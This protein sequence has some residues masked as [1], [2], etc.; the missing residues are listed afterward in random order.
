M[1]M[2]TSNPVASE[3][4]IQQERQDIDASLRFPVL[5]L[6]TTALGWLLVSILLGFIASI[7]LHSPEFL[8]N[9]SWLTYGRVSPAYLHTFIYGWAI[10][11]GL[12]AALWIIAR[13]NGVVFGR[14]LL[15]VIAGLVWNV[16]VI[17]GTLEILSGNSQGFEFF[18][19][20]RYVVVILLIGYSL[21]AAWS[22][23]I[24]KA[25][26]GIKDS[27]SIWYFIAAIIW[28]PWLLGAAALILTA[29]P[30]HGVVLSLVSAWFAQNLIGLWF[31][32]V[33]LGIIYYLIPKITG[34]P[35]YSRSLASLG[36]WSFALISGWTSATR[37]TGGPL[38]VWLVTVGIGASLL[39]LI[40]VAA[41]SANLFLSLQGN[42]QKI[43]KEPA[44]GFAGF[45][46]LAWLFASRL[47]IV[48]SLRSISQITHFTQVSVA[49][50][51]LFLLAFYS[52][53]V[54]GAMYYIIPRLI[55]R[56]WVSGGF[57]KIHF[58]GAIWGI[59]LLVAILLVSG[60]T[61][62]VAWNDPV[63]Y[64]SAVSV[65]ETFLSFLRV[66]GLA[67]LMITASTLVFVLHFLIVGIGSLRC[68]CCCTAKVG[69]DI[70]P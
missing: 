1:S 51:Y 47:A 31:V 9:L 19:F 42:F 2:L 22:A 27:V 24:L 23:V 64:P 56:T 7:K 37:F 49:G 60:L 26:E 43:G 52:M 15:P 8:G 32:S 65:T 39:T 40:P 59:C 14:P 3:A 45:A 55:G 38:T 69:E 6:F 62:G 50:T 68:C 54:F 11:S 20:P 16:G 21:I 18:E 33:G 30:I 66:T 48:T 70:K 4:A 10:P 36:F 28:F 67:W 46:G 34:R 13:V 5:F 17:A 12:G 25:G 57:I 58:W 53:A 41:V 35:I 44:L 63:K 29:A 61:Q